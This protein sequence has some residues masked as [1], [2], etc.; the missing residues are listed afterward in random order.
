MAAERWKLTNL[1]LLEFALEG[2]ITIIGV[3]SGNPDWTV[4]DWRFHYNA[5]KEIERRIKLVK[6]A[7]G[8]KND[9]DPS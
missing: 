7:E 5:Q 3:N 2:V 1:E 9:H 6:H 8:A 4:D